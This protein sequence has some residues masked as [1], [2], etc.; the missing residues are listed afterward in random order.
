MK[1]NKK[2][3]DNKIMLPQNNYCIVRQDT[4]KTCNI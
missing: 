3:K 1:I 4:I 2:H